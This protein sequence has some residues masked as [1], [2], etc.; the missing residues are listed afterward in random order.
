MKFSFFFKKKKNFNF[1][2]NALNYRTDAI[3]PVA[4]GS[5]VGSGVNT[6]L[7]TASTSNTALKTVTTTTVRRGTTATKTYTTTAA[8]TTATLA[9]GEWTDW[10]KFKAN[11][12]NLGGWLELEKVFNQYWWDQYAPNADDEWTF[13]KTL[14]PRCAS[15]MEHHYA[16]YITTQDI[17]KIAKVGESLPATIHPIEDH[18]H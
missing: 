13:C 2:A 16:S 1:K 14:G 18:G 6:A 12:V 15:V 9:V 17:D 10:T 3:A 8:S 7:Y 11:G 4:G 5:A